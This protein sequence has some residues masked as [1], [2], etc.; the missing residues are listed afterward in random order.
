MDV[1]IDVDHF[2]SGVLKSE[3]SLS[4]LQWAFAG[5]SHITE[6]TRDEQ[7][8]RTSYHCVWDHWVDSRSDAPE[9]DEGDMLPQ[10]DGTVL[11]QGAS[12]DPATGQVQQYE[13][14]WEDLEVEPIGSKGKRSSYVVKTE[15]DEA[16]TRGLVVKVGGF[17]QGILKHNGA[18][19]VERW[20]K[21]AVDTASAEGET[22][23]KTTTRTRNDW[24]RVFRAGEAILPCEAICSR[25]EGK[26]GSSIVLKDEQDIKWRVV[27]EYYY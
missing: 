22:E 18:L 20:R 21:E 7:G 19:T 16:T 23:H 17:C 26:M 6:E 27:E 9:I 2:S 14:L 24:V 8:K 3:A 13:E 15:G 10:E 4:Y 25:T 5:R 1:R 12:T 11:E